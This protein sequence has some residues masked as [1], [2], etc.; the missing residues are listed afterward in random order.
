MSA[1]EVALVVSATTLT[2][3]LAVVRIGETV[4]AT[5][6]LVNLLV[7]AMRFRKEN[8]TAVVAADLAMRAVS[9]LLHKNNIFIFY[10]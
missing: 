6:F 2:A 7:F 5:A 8:V 10:V 3:V 1:T 9:S 4:V